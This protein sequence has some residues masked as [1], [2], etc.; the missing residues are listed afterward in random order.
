MDGIPMAQVYKIYTDFLAIIK[1]PC[2]PR[3][4]GEAGISPGKSVLISV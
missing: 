2:S 4:I 3:E 1:K